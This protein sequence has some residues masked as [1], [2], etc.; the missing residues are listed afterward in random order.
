MR[1]RFRWKKTLSAAM[2][3]AVA[4]ST[5]VLPVSAAG[6][7]GNGAGTEGRDGIQAE[8]FVAPDGDDAKGDGSAEKPF[9]SL[10]AARDAV[11][12]INDDM[13]GDIYVNVAKGE[14]YL[15]ETV[16]FSEEDSATNGNRIIYR[17]KDGLG[18]AKFIGGFT[19]DA[20]LWQ[21]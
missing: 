7:G 3:V 9:A 5:L 21:P 6:A 11:R 2:S 20:S 16:V 8:L 4:A 19:V 18:S 14:Y 10:E 13:T 12:K 15:D 17:S 1:R